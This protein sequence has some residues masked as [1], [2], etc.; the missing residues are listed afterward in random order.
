[1]LARFSSL[2]VWSLVAA[3]LVAWVLQLGARGPG[4]PPQTV[5]ASASP[6]AGVDLSRLLGTAPPPLPAEAMPA[7]PAVPAVPADA[8]LRL[9]GVV[10]PR[11][12]YTAGLALISV[13]GKPARAVARG[14]EIEPGGLRV[15]QVQ[16]RKVELGPA[17]GQPPT[18]ALE[19]P[20][21]P[22]AARGRPDAG[23]GGAAGLPG[24]VG[25]QP[26]NLPP[27]VGAPG[28]IG[29]AMVMPPKAGLSSSLGLP[30]GGPPMPVPVQQNQAEPDA[31]ET[32]GT[33]APQQMR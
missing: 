8:R 11:P 20:M 31:N 4:V 15:L 5:L 22:E 18:V 14:R 17:L 12:G 30:R 32:N 23:P 3:T 25:A 26:A 19:L 7:E 9:L 6:A 10:A 29:Q 27:V 2:V 16:H 24:Q 1:M 28:Q 13:D 33:P 21:L